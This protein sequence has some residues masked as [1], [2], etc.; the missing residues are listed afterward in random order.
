MIVQDAIQLGKV[1][2]EGDVSVKG[3][4]GLEK[5]MQNA[6][7]YVRIN[8]FE[9]ALETYK[10]ITEKYP[11]DWRG[12]WGCF[13]TSN[14]YIPVKYND[15][16]GPKMPFV[17]PF[18]NENWRNN[19]LELADDVNKSVINKEYDNLIAPHL[20]AYEMYTTEYSRMHN[21][22]R[23]KLSRYGVNILKDHY[24]E[25]YSVDEVTSIMHFKTLTEPLDGLWLVCDNVPGSFYNNVLWAVNGISQQ[26]EVLLGYPFFITRSSENSDK[27]QIC[28]SD[29]YIRIFL[30]PADNDNICMYVEDAG[31]KNLYSTQ[32]R[33]AFVKDASLLKYKAPKTKEPRILI[34][35]NREIRRFLLESGRVS[36]RD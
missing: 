32:Y 29:H 8:E 15:L 27:I 2:I 24:L 30:Y 33:N 5:M 19:A 4:A 9:R 17:S 20:K 1:Q 14:H 12:W 11:E 10:E 36:L 23:A 22:F 3:I 6:A 16:K 31:K 21:N 18:N 35:K 13:K 28:K 25:L 7:T 34:P 26:G